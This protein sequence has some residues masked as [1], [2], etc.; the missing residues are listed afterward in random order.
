MEFLRSDMVSPWMA[1]GDFNVVSFTKEQVSGSMVNM[2]NVEEFN[3]AMF[4]CGLSSMEFERKP[5]T[6][7]NGSM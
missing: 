6:W 2:R 1:V 3:T 4:N 5:F 7:A